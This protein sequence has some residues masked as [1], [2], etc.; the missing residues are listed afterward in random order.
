LLKCLIPDTRNFRTWF[1]YDTPNITTARK[2]AAMHFLDAFRNY[3]FAPTP[4]IPLERRPLNID[5]EASPDFEVAIPI[6]HRNVAKIRAGEG[7]RAQVFEL[8]RNANR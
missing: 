4:K 6:G 5:K 1:E 3:H 2:T 8:R 7:K